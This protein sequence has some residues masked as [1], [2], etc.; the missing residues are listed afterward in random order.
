ML[1]SAAI[2]RSQ[3]QR[4]KPSLQSGYSRRQWRQ[5]PQRLRGSS[6]PARGELSLTL[7]ALE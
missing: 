4:A 6:K 2:S 7:V 5:P 1:L 3:A